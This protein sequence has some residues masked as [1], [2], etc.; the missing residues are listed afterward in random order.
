MRWALAALLAVL[1]GCGPKAEPEPLYIGH[2][3]PLSGSDRARGE[4]AR[5]GVR[6]AVEEALTADVRCAGRP[7]AVR[8]VDDRG[9]AETVRAEATRLLAVNRVPALLG[10]VDPAFN[11]ALARTVQPS[12]VPVLLPTELPEPPR[13]DNIFCLEV[14]PAE[15]GRALAG[16]AHEDLKATRA[17]VVVRE[18]DPVAGTLAA[19][20][21]EEW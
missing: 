21:V 16:F 19:A 14:S 2:L 12:G 8:H 15:R 3:L 10:G 18:G 6:L 20:F 11:Q 1:S 5:Q 4:E 17:A 9:D 7:L 13:A